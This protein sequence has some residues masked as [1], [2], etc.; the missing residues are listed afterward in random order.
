M[1]SANVIHGRVVGVSD[2]D[3]ITVIDAKKTQFVDWL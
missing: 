3:S 1:A 2:G